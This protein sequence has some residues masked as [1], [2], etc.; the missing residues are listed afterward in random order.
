[1]GE[2]EKNSSSQH[3]LQTLLSISVTYYVAYYEHIIDIS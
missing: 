3:L 1:M 2:I